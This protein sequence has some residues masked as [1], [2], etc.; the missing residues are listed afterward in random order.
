MGISYFSMYR[1]SDEVVI[2][3]MADGDKTNIRIL[4]SFIILVYLVIDWDEIL[5]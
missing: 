3:N 2:V 1:L 5:G 4:N